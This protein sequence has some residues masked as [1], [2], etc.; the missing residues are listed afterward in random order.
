M[1]HRLA[2]VRLPVRR[3]SP[4]WA[5]RRATSSTAATVAADIA[6]HANAAGQ[7]SL[8]S[9]GGSSCL[10]ARHPPS[11]PRS[12]TLPATIAAP[13]PTRSHV[14][15]CEFSFS[16]FMRTQHRR[17]VEQLSKAS[18]VPSAAREG[19]APNSAISLTTPPASSTLLCAPHGDGRARRRAPTAVP[20]AGCGCARDAGTCD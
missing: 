6:A 2:G 12:T 11:S 7:L 3:R 20:A 1:L 15:F 5:P 18:R 10:I 17:Q 16:V 14:V 8:R 4:R 9:P 13:A 19:D